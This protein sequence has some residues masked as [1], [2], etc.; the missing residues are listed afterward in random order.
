MGK[1]QVIEITNANIDGLS[2]VCDE[3]SF[4]CLSQRLRVFKDSSAHRQ[5]LRVD[6]LEE[7][8]FQLEADVQALQGSQQTAAAAQAG[9][10]S[11][12]RALKGWAGPQLDSAIVPALPPICA[13][14]AAATTAASPPWPFPPADVLDSQDRIGAFVVLCSTH[15]QTEIR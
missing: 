10:E 4:G 2:V 14:P 8:V 15:Q 7:R 5:K 13:P 12:A 11:D 9:L 6:A 3:F 1:V